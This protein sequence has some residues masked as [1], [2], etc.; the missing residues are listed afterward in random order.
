MSNRDLVRLRHMRD[1]LTHGYFDVDLDV[2]WGTVKSD[3]PGLLETLT[4]LVPPDPPQ[5]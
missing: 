3:L 4:E 2:V 1:R 5:A